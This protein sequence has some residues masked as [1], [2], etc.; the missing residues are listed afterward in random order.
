MLNV[1]S[2]FLILGQ[3]EEIL[4]LLCI[5]EDES[6]RKENRRLERSFRETWRIA[7]AHHQRFRVQPAIGDPMA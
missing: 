7:V 2:D 4:A 6:R 3:I 1:I 5:L